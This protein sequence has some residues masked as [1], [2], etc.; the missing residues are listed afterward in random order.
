MKTVLVTGGCGF[1]GSNFISMYL[2]AHPGQ[3]VINL[4]KLTY[5]GNPE[6]LNDLPVAS[7]Y[8]FVHGDICDKAL[9]KKLF[10]EFDIGG[11]FHFAAESHVDNS[12]SGPEIF[13]ETNVLGTFQL[14]E[15]A[16]NHWMEKP[17]MY[18]RGYEN[19]RFLHVSTDEVYG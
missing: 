1:I 9:L 19:S 12:I 18:K 14:L 17:S 16:R 8:Q 11:V 15:A 4:D 10:S 13:V 7:A 5:A 2:A 3:R 6:N